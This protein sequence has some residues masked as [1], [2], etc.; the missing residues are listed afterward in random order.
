MTKLSLGYA[1]TLIALHGVANLGFGAVLPFTAVY[2]SGLPDVGPLGAAL[3]YVCVGMANLVVAAV[4]TGGLVRPRTPW[5]GTVGA[6]L[7]I[8]GC[9]L[10]AGA[11]TRPTVLAAAL[12]NGAGQGC[13]MAAIVP[14][15]NAAT[16]ESHR[17]RLFARRYQVLNF[18]MAVGA[19]IAGA[20]SSL[21]GREVFP[22][23]YVGQAAVI[24]PLGLVL[25][26]AIPRT[27]STS[28]PAGADPVETDP[29]HPGPTGT[30]SA[31]A[32]PA[33]ALPLRQLVRLA[34]GPTLF[35]F[36]GYAFAFSQLES[37]VPLVTDRLLHAGTLTV[38]LLIALNVV[39]IIVAQGAVTRRL[40]SSTERHGLRIAVLLWIAGFGLAALTALGSAWSAIA[41]LAGFIVLFSL[42][43]CAYACSFHP[44]LISRVPQSE[45]TRAS[46]LTNAAM[47]VGLF[48]GPALGV[49]LVVSGSAP[50]VWACLAL[51][52]TAALR[53]VHETAPAR[54][55]PRIP[56]ERN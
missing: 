13:F 53:T 47:G 9:L 7:A 44:W 23:L 1:R 52:C 12:A 11:D 45:L 14:M 3:Y 32:H 34:G 33:T 43:E 16:P 15:L 49:G 10:L 6:V 48:T 54:T 31:D 28:P 25:A 50:L 38:S 41:G 39:V 37:T 26:W 21:I 20:T 24:V 19:L 29:A 36:A 51:C 40:E 27:P 42:G 30:D 55:E 18:S 2:L 17:R 35:Q 5:L 8:F 4:L 56:V 22:W 46:A